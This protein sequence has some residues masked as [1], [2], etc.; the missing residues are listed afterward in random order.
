MSDNL[1][2]S[3]N[4]GERSKTELFVKLLTSNH[5]R[6]YAFIL[7]MVPNDSDADDLMQETSSILWEKFAQFVPGTD[8]AAWAMTIAK[9]R[10]L[11]SRKKKKLTVPLSNDVI[12]L[13]AGESEKVLD[14]SN[15]RFAALRKCLAKL[16]KREMLFVKMRYK[17]GFS[18][19]IIGQRIG[20]SAKVVYR[21][22]SK[23]I[24]LLARCIH[25]KLAMEGAR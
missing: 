18:A 9:Y 8:F 1:E 22:E 21:S 19:R 10:V 20:A 5:H 7:F 17:D 25:R 15:E 2:N 6:I 4:M 11:N 14:E 24:G 12:D 23:I 3:S 16:D 13:L